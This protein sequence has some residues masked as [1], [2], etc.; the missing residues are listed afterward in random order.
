MKESEFVSKMLYAESMKKL[1]DRP[2]YWD[3]YRR[4]LRKRYHGDNFGTIEEHEKWLS[5]INDRDVS[6]SERGRGYRDGIA[7]VTIRPM[8]CLRC[9]YQWQPRA[10]AKPTICPK[11]KSPYWDKP[12]S[13]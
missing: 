6:R 10:E 4:G 5:L 11:C 9:G 3:G 12:K 13:I 2:D 8:I 7:E 1:D